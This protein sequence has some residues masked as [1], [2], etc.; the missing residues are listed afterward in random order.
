M[1]EVTIDNPLNF[2]LREAEI[3]EV[4]ARIFLVH[5]VTVA[6]VGIHLVDEA[7]M[8]RL[9]ENYKHH[10]G[11]TDVLTFPMHDP[12]QPTPTFLETSE[13]QV[14]YGDIF[15]CYPVIEQEAQDESVPVNE[16]IAFLTE[17]GAL[18]LLG[19]HHD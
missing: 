18:H 10:V 1:I 19:V 7:E 11:S 8:T 5:S 4:I 17:H 16:K 12:E 15:L 13:T 6:K 14:E 2:P 3:E 9:N